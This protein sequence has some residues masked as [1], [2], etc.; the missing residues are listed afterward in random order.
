MLFATYDFCIKDSQF[1]KS[2]QVR[3]KKEGEGKLAT[4]LMLRAI[5]EFG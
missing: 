1:L 3:S 4:S 2:I 5:T